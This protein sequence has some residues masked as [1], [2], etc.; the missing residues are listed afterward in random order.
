MVRI[1]LNSQNSQESFQALL[2]PFKLDVTSFCIVAGN[3]LLGKQIY[4]FSLV[5]LPS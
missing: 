5:F 2:L 1:Y 4:F 3:F